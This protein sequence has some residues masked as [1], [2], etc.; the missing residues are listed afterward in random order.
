ML[1]ASRSS[2]CWRVSSC[3]RDVDQK[4]LA[5]LLEDLDHVAAKADQ[6]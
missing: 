5:G 1:S 6:T 3:S 2:S 4:E